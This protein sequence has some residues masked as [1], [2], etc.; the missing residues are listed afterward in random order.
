L[1]TL[2]GP[3]VAQT[4]DAIWRDAARNRDLPVRIRLPEHGSNI[5]LV[6]FSPGLGGSITGGSLWAKAW[7][8]RGL[9]VIHLEH[10]GSDAAVYRTPGTPDERRARLRAAASAEQLHARVADSGFILDQ[11]AERR[12]EGACDLSR[13]DRSRIGFAGHSMGAW[14]AQGLAGQ[15]YA[16]RGAP[17]RDSRIKAAI[18]F[19]PS[20]LTVDDPARAFG[21]ITI[22]FLSITGSRDGAVIRPANTPPDQTAAAQRTG[23][24]RG[25]PPGQK[26]LLVFEDGDHM[27]F[28]GNLRRAPTAIDNH[29][30]TAT[31]AATTAFWG[32][33][34]LA[35]AE[36]AKAMFA[37]P[38]L[39]APGDRFETK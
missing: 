9:A 22:P 5:P 36:D 7:V 38:K 11:L 21:Q 27:V 20:A 10:P 15:N 14:T 39:L 16:G 13:I 26:Y 3:A 12:T 23:P 37:L 35:S 25:M 6:L 32:M 1:L 17:F 34:L 2:A 24:W 31:V 8:A 28:S 29:I 19:S 18:A 4:C 33:T 30:Q